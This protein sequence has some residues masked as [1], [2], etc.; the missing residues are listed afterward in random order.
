[1]SL[2]RLP[3]V[4]TVSQTVLLEVHMDDP[5]GRKSGV[6]AQFVGEGIEQLDGYPDRKDILNQ[7][8]HGVLSFVLVVHSMA[9]VGFDGAEGMPRAAAPQTHNAPARS[10]GLRPFDA[11]LTVSMKSWSSGRDDGCTL[12]ALQGAIRASWSLETCDPIDAAQWTPD[13]PSRGQC[14]VS[15]LVVHDFFGGELLEAE[16]LFDDGSRQGFH[17]W[18]RLPSGDVD[19]TSEQFTEHEIVQEPRT[20]D[21]LPDA[22]W[23]AHEQYLLFRERVRAALEK[24]RRDQH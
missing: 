8:G 22:P 7:N 18:N 19:L 21:R 1:M 6:G 10:F 14:A 3:H 11:V 15:A 23:R 16:V 13:N 9:G 2:D 17:Y 20:V 5:T 24:Q 4:D 12:E